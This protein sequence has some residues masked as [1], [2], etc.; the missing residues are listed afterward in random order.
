MWR[1]YK[2]ITQ[3][4]N[5]ITHA[6]ECWCISSMSNDRSTS[7]SKFTKQSQNHR[8]FCIIIWVIVNVA[9]KPVSLITQ[10]TLSNP[11][12]KYNLKIWGGCQH[13]PC[14]SG[15][16]RC[17]LL[18]LTLRFAYILF[19]CLRP[20]MM[21]VPWYFFM[22]PCFRVNEVQLHWLQM[23]TVASISCRV[24]EFMSHSQHLLFNLHCLH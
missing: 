10:I 13:V 24:L 3:F 6:C 18:H 19:L 5:R 8:M 12:C 17:N 9:T 2:C 16:I 23:T 15:V 11:T 7:Q 22:Q 4:F 20:W 14:P 1:I 21:L